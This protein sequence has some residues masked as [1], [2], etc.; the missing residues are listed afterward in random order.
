[1]Q[2]KDTFV[3]GVIAG[4]VG[5]TVYQ[6]FVWVFYLIGIAKIT[7]YHLGAYILIKPGS[8]ITSI[9]SQLL[10]M[11]QHYALSVLFAVIALYLLRIMGTDYAWLKG[12]FWGAIIYFLVYGL[13][14][15]AVIPVG[16]LQP[17]LVTSTIFMFGNVIFGV[18]TVL[19]LVKYFD[20]ESS[21]VE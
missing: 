2:Q 1:M 9:S 18:V 20:K 13:L 8:D 21:L 14:A 6:G 12:L 16:I 11:V 5:G 7:P 10:G 15:K 19:T 4:I 17:D 3:I